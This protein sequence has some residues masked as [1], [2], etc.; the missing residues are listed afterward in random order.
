MLS[1]FPRSVALGLLVSGSS[2]SWAAEPNMSGYVDA[3]WDD[4]SLNGQMQLNFTDGE[5]G[6]GTL[7]GHNLNMDYR[8]MQLLYGVQGSYQI[9][10]SYDQ[11]PREGRDNVRTVYRAVDHSTLT[12]PAGWVD[13]ATTSAMPLLNSS[14]IPVDLEFQRKRF[15]AGISVVGGEHWDLSFSY[16]RDKKNGLTEGTGAVAASDPGNQVV[17]NTGA[18]A[19][20]LHLDEV[21]DRAEL[22]F[23]YQKPDYQLQGRFQVSLFDNDY[24][25]MSWQDPYTTVDAPDVAIGQISR[26]PDNEFYQAS[27][28]G[29]YQLA[30]RTRLSLKW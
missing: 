3:G 5:Q 2:S 26:E 23:D 17:A 9:E 10:L 27:L 4:G 8:S 18:V 16:R 13:A 22:L 29:G 20:P 6:R 15:K 21:T 7:V 12:L 14:L 1:R 24:S 28:S 19:F 25:A 30:S 11:Q